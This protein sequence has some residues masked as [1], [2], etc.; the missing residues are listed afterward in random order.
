MFSFYTV[1][2]CPRLRQ[3]RHGRLSCST[4][5]MSYKTTCLVTCDEGYRLEGSAKLTCQ[6]NAQWDGVEPRCVGKHQ[7]ALVIQLYFSLTSSVFCEDL[8]LKIDS[9]DCKIKTVHTDAGMQMNMLSY[10]PPLVKRLLLQI[11]VFQIT[12]ISSF[13]R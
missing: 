6:G 1:R 2:T 8:E 4:G 5:E 10:S 12:E 11:P 13:K 9:Y 3:P 7:K